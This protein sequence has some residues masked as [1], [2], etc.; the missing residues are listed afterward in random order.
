MASP[1]RSPLRRQTHHAGKESPTR[2]K[3][4]KSPIAKST[5]PCQ[6]VHADPEAENL[7][8]KADALD[9]EHDIAHMSPAL[10]RF[11]KVLFCL[12]Q[13]I[14]SLLFPGNLLLISF[15]RDRRRDFCPHDQ[16]DLVNIYR[17]PKELSGQPWQSLTMYSFKLQAVSTTRGESKQLSGGPC[18]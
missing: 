15:G 1:L 10:Q 4:S 5:R 14:L 17:T 3:Q 16:N 2:G 12:I 13:E 18:G 8:L 9:I 7:R 11:W 6:G